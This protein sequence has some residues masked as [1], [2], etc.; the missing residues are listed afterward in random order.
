MQLRLI[1][2][3]SLGTLLLSACSA[4]PAALRSDCVSRSKGTS[5]KPCWMIDMPSEG[6]VKQGAYSPWIA[7][8]IHKTE[9]KLVAQAASDFAQQRMQD[10]SFDSEVISDT[11]VVET[12]GSNGSTENVAVV[13]TVNI[14]DKVTS[15]SVET[16]KIKVVK[17]DSYVYKPTNTVYVWAVE[18]R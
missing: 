11:R 13:S 3:M 16:I 14:K 6:V 18:E 2:M 8:T 5:Q 12:S 9:Q 17:K 1:A 7:D 4:M 10:V 15:E